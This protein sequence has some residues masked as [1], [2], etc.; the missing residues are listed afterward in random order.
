MGSCPAKL[1]LLTGLKTV[2]FCSNALLDKHGKVLKCW[3][4]QSSCNAAE[5]N[6]KQVQAQA[7]ATTAH[8]EASQSPAVVVS[9]QM[10]LGLKLPPMPKG[11]KPGMPIPGILHGHVILDTLLCTC[12]DS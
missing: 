1:L 7:A 12:A 2:A 4:K 10:P 11:W 6:Q 9:A 3:V 5:C 8:I